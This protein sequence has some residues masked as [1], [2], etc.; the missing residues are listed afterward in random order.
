MNKILLITADWCKFCEAPKK[1]LKQWIDNGQIEVVELNDEI[2]NKYN[3]RGVPSCIV[4]E[5][6]N[7]VKI[8]A[9][10]EIRTQI[11]QYLI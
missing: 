4:L 5:D 11:K 3:I 6:E 1:A 8:I 7:V 9:G 10:N 2:A